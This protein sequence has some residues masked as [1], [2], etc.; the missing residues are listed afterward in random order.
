MIGR[1]LSH[2]E[3]IERLGEGGMGTV[4]RALDSRL[5]RPVA[6][7]VLRLE[8]MGS[9]DRTR[10]FKQEARAASA[11]NHPNIVTIHDIGSEAGVD[12]I[13][14]E[15]VAGA[16][17]HRLIPPGG[18]PLEQALDYAV[19]ITSAL[20]AAHAVGI[21]HR[22]IKPA[23]IVV[24][25]DGR[26]KVLD[27]GLAKLTERP[28]PSDEAS[29]NTAPP[30]TQLGGFLGTAGYAAPEQVE[31]KAADARSDVFAIGVVL[32]ELLAGRRVFLRDSHGSTLAAV[33][34][35]TP[36][37]LGAIRRDVPSELER[38][39]FRCLEKQPGA[40]YQSAA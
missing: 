40:R 15:Y 31:G 25:P 32:Y 28:V 8:A 33:L 6:I 14:M 12:F 24:S 4:Y 19:Q 22:D 29:T 34:R 20:A 11:L 26:A 36:T 35:D 37:L 38:I 21:L 10:R 13:V 23:N 18:M 2:Y 16:P 7:K 17:L 1:R 30:Q 39:V 3:M 9:E 27:F 5:G